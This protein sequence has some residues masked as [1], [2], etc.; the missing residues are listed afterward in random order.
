M[1]ISYYTTTFLA[2]LS[3]YNIVL[4][5]LKSEK[6]YN[7]GKSL[8][9]VPAIHTLAIA[10]CDYIPIFTPALCT[11]Q[12]VVVVPTIEITTSGLIHSSRL[13]R[14]WELDK[15]KAVFKKEQSL[16]SVL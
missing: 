6:K 2:K 5:A 8:I 16:L 4:A 13:S 14:L 9:L 15:K 3:K 1:A 10:L 7:L 12:R 11:T